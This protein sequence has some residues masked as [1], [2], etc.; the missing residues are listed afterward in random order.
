MATFNLPLPPQPTM[1]TKYAVVK[2]LNDCY[3][4]FDTEEAGKNEYVERHG[5]S[6][7]KDLFNKWHDHYWE[8]INS[9]VIVVEEEKNYT[10][11]KLYEDLLANGFTPYHSK[12]WY[13]YVTEHNTYVI[14][15]STFIGTYAI[16]IGI[17]LDDDHA[18]L[19]SLTYSPLFHLNAE[20]IKDIITHYERRFDQLNR[21]HQ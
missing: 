4:A 8:L 12:A 2:T 19:Q 3:G 16:S 6:T 5:K 20:Q 10:A 15:I 14:G 7:R 1:V 11:E 13:K 17:L 21:L 9:N 18:T